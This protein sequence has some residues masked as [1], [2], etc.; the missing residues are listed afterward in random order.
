MLI[1]SA[2][3]VPSGVQGSPT[4]G[5]PRPENCELNKSLL[6]INHRVRGVQSQRQKTSQ[7]G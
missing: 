2:L 6:Y 7:D 3:G 5:L 1:L 4:H